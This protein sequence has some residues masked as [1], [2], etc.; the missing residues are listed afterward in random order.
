MVW[1]MIKKEY[2]DNYDQ[3]WIGLGVGIPSVNGGKSIKCQY[4]LNMVKWKELYSIDD[5]DEDFYEEDGNEED[6]NA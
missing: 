6:R 3:L 5:V 4:T 2:V 1:L